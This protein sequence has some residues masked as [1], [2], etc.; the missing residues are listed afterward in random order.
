[1]IIF[2]HRKT[3][4]KFNIHSKNSQKIENKIISSNGSKAST[5]KPHYYLTE[6]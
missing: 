6:I 5:E 1:M 4:T 3:M 2:V